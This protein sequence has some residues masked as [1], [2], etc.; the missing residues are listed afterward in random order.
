M[1]GTAIVN[2]DKH[3][4]DISTEEHKDELPFD[5]KAFTLI[6]ESLKGDTG[7]RDVAIAVVNTSAILRCRPDKNSSDL[8]EYSD[9]KFIWRRL[10]E[11]TYL[12][13]NY[14]RISQDLRY[15]VV[16]ADFNE[17]KMDLK[18]EMVKP[19]DEGEY[20]C[21]YRGG[22]FVH[23]KH[24]YL[25]IL[26]PPSI[27]PMGSSSTT[28]VVREQL[29]QKLT[30]NVSGVPTP[31]LKW[32]M[33]TTDGKVQ[34]SITKKDYPRFL[35]TD[36]ALIISNV[37]RDLRG[38][39]TCIAYNGIDRKVSRSIH[40]DVYFRPVVKMGAVTMNSHDARQTTTILATVVGNPIYSLYWEFKHKP[41]RGVS[42]D[43]L[44]TLFGDK[45]CVVS[46]R[47]V[48]NPMV[49]KTKLTIY[50]L[51]L[52]DY[53]IYTCVVHSPFGMER[54]STEVVSRLSSIVNILNYSF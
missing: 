8:N 47:E 51:T 38:T 53:G 36:N 30:C 12:T 26:I 22:R 37:T 14:R 23:E 2:T 41:I 42:G 54:G 19:S 34:K 48:T 18:I 33:S 15:N 5:P 32:Y 16:M 10:E 7:L 28:V 40:L 50:N 52:E 46:D 6:K 20:I 45:Y 24:V 29:T 3:K 44:V 31:T 9:I 27:N 49:L 35:L 39:F 13:F 1:S 4:K 11:P 21:L 43:C 17:F 25:K